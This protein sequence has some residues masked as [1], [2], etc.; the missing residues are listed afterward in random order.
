MSDQII[1]TLLESLTDEQKAKLVAD[2]IASVDKGKAPEVKI[3]VNNEETV[4]SRAK[5]TVNE[6]FTVVR[7][8][9]LDR[10]KVPVR[11][12]KNEWVDDGEN[13]DP[14]FDPIKFEKMGKAS[15]NRNKVSKKSVECHVCGRSFDINPNLVYGEYVRCNRCT[16]R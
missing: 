6:D 8:E 14:D 5:I 10:R 2:L 9:S 3:Q 7:D 13:R 1:K 16:G 11:A 4:S 15:R 12:R